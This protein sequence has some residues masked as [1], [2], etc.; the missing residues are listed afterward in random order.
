MKIKLVV[1][2]AC[3]VC[4]IF[5][6]QPIWAS[7]SLDNRSDLIEVPSDL[8]PGGVPSLEFLALGSTVQSVGS[9]GLASA[10]GITQ[11]VCARAVPP[12][13][14]DGFSTQVYQVCELWVA[15]SCMDSYRVHHIWKNFKNVIGTRFAG[16]ELP[17]APGVD[18]RLN[19]TELDVSGVAEGSKIQV[20]DITGRLRMETCSS[21]ISGLSKGLYFIKIADKVFKIK[22]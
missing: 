8:L 22:I 16:I 4:A 20:Y 5:P 12:E 6:T 9:I 10:Q 15:S 17:L 14:T 19:G 2:T 1:L 11:I 13:I 7:G 21:C 3:M 18:I